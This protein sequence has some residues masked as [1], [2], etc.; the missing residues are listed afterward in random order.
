[1]HAPA[2]ASIVRSLLKVAL[3]F[4]TLKIDTGRTPK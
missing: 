1:M 4:G 3:A 2:M